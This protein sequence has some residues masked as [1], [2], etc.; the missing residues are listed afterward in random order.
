MT[1]L[2]AQTF[3]LAD[4]GLLREGYAADVVVFDD[5]RFADRATFEQPHQYP[6]GLSHVVVN[7]AEVFD[8]AQMTGARPGSA[9]RGAGAGA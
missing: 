6:A 8:G 9:L 2:P 5:A 4:R 7:G 1:S 3:R